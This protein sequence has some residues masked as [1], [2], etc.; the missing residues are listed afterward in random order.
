MVLG[1]DAYREF[2][3]RLLDELG[4]ILGEGGVISV[5]L[6]GSVA[7]GEGSANSDIDLLVIHGKDRT[8]PVSRS[9]N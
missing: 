1:Y 3:G 2:I 5:A 6:F 9:P 4:L 7:R 8:D